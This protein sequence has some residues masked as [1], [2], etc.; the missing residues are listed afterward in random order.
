VLSP[1]DD[2]KVTQ[3]N[4]SE[5]L[6]KA[7]NSNDTDQTIE[8]EQGGSGCGCKAD[9][10]GI[11]A[12]GQKALNLQKAES[13]A[14]SKQIK[15]ENKSLSVRFKSYGGGGDLMQS[16][17]SFAASFAGNFNELDQKVEQEQGHSRR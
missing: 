5:A 14:E 17:S 12:A 6:S 9:S 16:N 3:S 4:E 2:G 13:S 11:Q 1:G 10:V 15:P 8:Q 7:F